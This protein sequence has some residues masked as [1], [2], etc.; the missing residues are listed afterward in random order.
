MAKIKERKIIEEGKELMTFYT[1]D[2]N[3]KEYP[4]LLPFDTREDGT[5][6]P[7]LDADL[8]AIISDIY[9]KDADDVEHKCKR[10]LSTTL[11]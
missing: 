10:K 7:K 1:K 5:F 6:E 3:G 2:K 9:Y 11:E 4:M 8:S